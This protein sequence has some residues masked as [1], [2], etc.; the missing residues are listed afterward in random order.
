[1]LTMKATTCWQYMS[2]QSKEKSTGALNSLLDKED[3]N[4]SSI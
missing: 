3:E 4:I 2:K 1:M